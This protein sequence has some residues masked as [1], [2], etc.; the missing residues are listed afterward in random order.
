MKR[1]VPF[2]PWLALGLAFFGSLLLAAHYFPRPYDWHL[3]VMSL[4]AEPKFN[5]RAYGVACAGLHRFG[6]ADL[7]P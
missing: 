5:P 2:L 7:W 3:D 1:G 6:V 4:L